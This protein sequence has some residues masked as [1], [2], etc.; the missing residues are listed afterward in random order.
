ME[1]EQKYAA[2][3]M[4]AVGGGDADSMKDMAKVQQEKDAELA[5]VLSPEELE[6]YQLRLS[7]T[8][9]TLRMQMASFDPNEKEFRDIFKL[10]K[11]FEDEF[12]MAGMGATE[13]AE[14][15][16]MQAAQKQM[17]EQLKGL[18]GDTRYAEYERS[19]DY[20]FQSMYRV[21]E[22]NGLG[23]DAAVKVYDMKKAAEDQARA[24]RG[25]A[26][27]TKEQRTAALAGIRTETENAIQSVYGEKGFKSY[28][29]QGG[30]WLRGISPDPKPASNP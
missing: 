9:M 8:A 18:L 23:Q 4:K 27:L 28:Q 19:Q 1:I 24:V 2:K 12:G 20:S 6:D 22:R 29:S 21:A 13:K 25:D 15:E 14:K 30:Y 26:S 16:K 5:K 3:L 10:K 17:N 7:Q 11:S